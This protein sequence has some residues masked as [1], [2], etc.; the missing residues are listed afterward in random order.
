MRQMLQTNN[1]LCW[2]G[3]PL[4]QGKDARMQKPTRFASFRFV[5]L[6]PFWQSVSGSRQQTANFP[7]LLTALQRGIDVDSGFMNPGDHSYQFLDERG[8]HAAQDG[9]AAARRR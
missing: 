7:R 1:A 9:G 2:L 8:H 5:V 4:A 3:K 6:C